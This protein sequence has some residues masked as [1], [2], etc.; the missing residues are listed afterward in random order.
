M[1]TL[2]VR[3]ARAGERGAT[4]VAV[5]IILMVLTLLATSVFV[6]SST[7]SKVIKQ[8]SVDA[9]VKELLRK[10][11]NKF[12]LYLQA[13]YLD[14][15]GVE[16]CSTAD[17]RHSN[18]IPF[19]DEVSFLGLLYGNCKATPAIGQ[20]I[21]AA[22]ARD[23]AVNLALA[24]DT[25]RRAWMSANLGTECFLND[26]PSGAA[27]T[28]CGHPAFSYWVKRPVLYPNDAQIATWTTYAAKADNDNNVV[29][30]FSLR[31][32]LLDEET[33]ASI[34]GIEGILAIHLK[35]SYNCK[36]DGANPLLHRGYWNTARNDKFYLA[37]QRYLSSKKKLEALE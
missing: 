18:C 21:P 16:D 9:E 26:D 17:P 3:S 6:T 14:P 37:A 33:D 22:G 13:R 10:E 19:M 25:T 30:A 2:F 20:C 23:K 12:V 11:L 5:L 28:A 15:N 8:H 7:T 36:A 29:M 27:G 4:L 34:N 32:Y 31:I 35:C 24:A 1:T